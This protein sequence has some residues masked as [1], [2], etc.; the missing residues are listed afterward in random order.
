M[1]AIL[2]FRVCNNCSPDLC[3]GRK[4]VRFDAFCAV[5]MFDIH[6]SYCQCIGYKR[7]MASL[8]YGFCTHNCDLRLPGNLYQPVNALREFISLHIIGKTPK[9]TVFP[10]GIR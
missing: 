4:L 6:I 8:G 2:T 7:T 1:Q 10:P 9:G 3:K 5:D